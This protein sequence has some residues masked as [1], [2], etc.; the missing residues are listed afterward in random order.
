MGCSSACQIFERFSTALEWFGKRHM[1]EGVIIHILDDFV[2]M[3]QTQEL[4]KLYLNKFSKI[5]ANIGIPMAPGKRV[6]P[7]TTLTFLGI[8]FNTEK[9]ETRLPD[10]KLQKC[11]NLVEAFLHR[12][13]VTL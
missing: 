5:C 3:A 2:I 12:R 8:E 11:F 9:Q 10:D 6:G 7:A 4:G 1:P 13:K